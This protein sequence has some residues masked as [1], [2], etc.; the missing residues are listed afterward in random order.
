MKHILAILSV[1][2]LSA[3][4]SSAKLNTKTGEISGLESHDV[5]NIVTNRDYIDGKIKQPQKAIVS[6]KAHPGQQIMINAAEFTVW[7]PSGPQDQ[8]AQPKQ[9]KS[10][11][12]QNTEAVGGLVQ[13]AT[14]LGIAVLAKEVAETNSNN[15]LESQRI[16]S[17]ERT[18]ITQT[19][20]EEAGKVVFPPVYTVPMGS[21]P[22]PAE[23]APAPAE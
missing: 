14:P 20:I 12:V 11:F 18:A 22:T 16:Q 7:Q 17:A 9:A 8:I 21:V 2:A 19:A 15:N 3:C 5:A 4:G 23:P 1:L 10:T 13:K 6:M